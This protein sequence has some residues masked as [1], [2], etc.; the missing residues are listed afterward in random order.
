MSLQL[1]SN[2]KLPT[3]AVRSPRRRAALTPDRVIYNSLKCLTDIPG[4]KIEFIDGIRKFKITNRRQFVC[5][6]QLQ[7][8][9]NRQMYRVYIYIAPAAGQE[10]VNAGYAVMNIESALAANDFVNLYRIIYKHRPNQM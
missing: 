3:S 4:T 5:D 2:D 1:T 8:D 9:E 10:K 6:Y 7:W